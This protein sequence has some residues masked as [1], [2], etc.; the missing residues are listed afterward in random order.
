M[1]LFRGEQLGSPQPRQAYLSG[2]GTKANGGPGT[3]QLM[4]IPKYSIRYELVS[5]PLLAVDPVLRDINIL[6]DLA[7]SYTALLNAA[8]VSHV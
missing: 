1:L 5:P 2:T 8:L 6:V 3:A 4:T 7:D